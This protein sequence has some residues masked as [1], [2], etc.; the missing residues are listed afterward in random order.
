MSA[1]SCQQVS[2]KLIVKTFYPQASCNLVTTLAGS[3]QLASYTK[4]DFHQDD[5]LS[6]NWLNPPRILKMDRQLYSM[7][8]LHYGQNFEKHSNGK[9]HNHSIKEHPEI[10]KTATFG[11]EML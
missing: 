1:A 10:S 5:E 8:R 9:I 11:R 2:C 3:L 4:S 6:S 7:D